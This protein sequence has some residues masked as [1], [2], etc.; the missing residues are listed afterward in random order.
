M[1]RGDV[2][3]NIA[4]NARRRIQH[5]MEETPREL[6]RFADDTVNL[7]HTKTPV[8]AGALVAAIVRGEPEYKDGVF[9]IG[10]APLDALPDYAFMLEYGTIGK[11]TAGAPDWYREGHKAAT[12]YG[13]VPAEG[14]GRYGEGFS[15][16]RSHRPHPGIRPH[17]FF[18]DAYNT[19][20]PLIPER[21]RIML[22][23]G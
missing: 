14:R 13:F 11:M 16:R 4:A 21:I 23:G 19:I 1:L 20:K 3:Q 12:E 17:H 10:V 15:E 18:T 5:I 9:S 6:R 7:A 2:Q 8:R 22:L